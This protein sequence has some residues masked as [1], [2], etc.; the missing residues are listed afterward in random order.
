MKSIIRSDIFGRFADSL[1]SQ[2]VLEQNDCMRD[3]C[4]YKSQWALSLCYSLLC[5]SR[6]HEPK[7][8]F[9]FR[10]KLVEADY[11]TLPYLDIDSQVRFPRTKPSSRNGNSKWISSSQRRRI[12]KR[13][14]EPAYCIQANCHDFENPGDQMFCVINRC[15]EWHNF[16]SYYSR[17][18][19]SLLN[20]ILAGKTTMIYILSN[21]LI[22]GFK[23]LKNLCLE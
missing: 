2:I 6:R 4:R 19:S 18:T 5:R 7:D 9:I 12:D 8:K 1:P 3:K 14:D 21:E 16:I 13:I 11:E 20:N 22:L 23:Y 10:N 15:I 17:N